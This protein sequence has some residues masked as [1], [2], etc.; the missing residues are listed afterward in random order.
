MG[1]P[2][3]CMEIDQTAADVIDLRQWDMKRRFGW[4]PEYPVQRYVD[5]L[6]EST[7]YDANG[8]RV[9]NPVF[10]DLP[11]QAA[12]A[13]G[14]PLTR[15]KLPPRDPSLVVLAG[16]V[17]VPWQDIARTGPDGKPDL[18]LGYKTPDDSDSQQRIDWTLIVGD[19]YNADPTQR[20]PRDPLMVEAQDRTAPI[21]KA[22][23]KHPVTQET[24]DD[25]T[26]NSINGHEWNATMASDLQYTCFFAL[27]QPLDCTT[28]EYSCPCANPDPTQMGVAAQQALQAV[29]NPVCEPPSDPTQPTSPG[30][31]QSAITGSAAFKQYRAGVYSGR[32][33]L[34]ILQGFSKEGGATVVA[35]LCASNV[36]T[37]DPAHASDLDLGYRPAM[38]AILKRAMPHLG[39]A[40]GGS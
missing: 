14:K 22:G 7:I 13:A 2:D 8:Y 15:A 16:I 3:T 37:A 35:S 9:P 30:A 19:P 31:G 27:T 25:H 34:Q 4:D 26:W 21:A 24:L 5:G 11:F 40:C 39:G 20:D 29:D 12:N 18:R 36:A 23:G 33:H 32:K 1:Q 17:G 10:Q 6:R 28:S 38:D